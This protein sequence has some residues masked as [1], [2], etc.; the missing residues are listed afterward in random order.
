M[1][2]YWNNGF[3]AYW[4]FKQ[5]PNFIMASPIILLSIDAILVYLRS[6][7]S[8]NPMYDF[9]GILAKPKQVTSTMVTFRNNRLL[10]PF[11]VHLMVIVFSSCFF[12]NVQVNKLFIEINQNF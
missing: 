12:M 1:Q 7:E 9:F 2:T 3:L 4:Q 5:I 8:E 6:V 11:A 10:F